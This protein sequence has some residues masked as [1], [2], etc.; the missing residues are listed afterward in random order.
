MATFFGTNGVDNHIGT[1]E[2]DTI[3]GAGE[4]DNLNGSGG[5]DNIYGDSGNDVLIGGAG[6]DFIYGGEDND[7]LNATGEGNDNLFG[8]IGDDVYEVSRTTDSITEGS[9]Q[10]IDTVRSSVTNNLQAIS[11]NVENLV[12]TGASHI[13]G[14]G[15]GNHNQITGNNGNNNLSGSA[16]NDTLNGRGGN[17]ILTG[18][19]G[20]DQFLFDTPLP[21]SGIDTINDFMVGNDKIVLDK[22]VFS[23]LNTVAGNFLLATEFVV[24]SVPAIGEE[25]QAAINAEEIIYNTVTGNL[26]YNP[27]AGVTGFGVGG[28][29][30]AKIVNSPDNF[31]NTDLRVIA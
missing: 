7:T 29:Q 30:F 6:L 21:A 26:F 9:N 11:F 13:N 31:S 16:G 2:A 22:T 27:N 3:F 20:I 10:G 18:G 12:L 19:S 8:G 14:T 5:N 1:V 24:I 15:N 28:G 25:I 23:T 4:N 17:D